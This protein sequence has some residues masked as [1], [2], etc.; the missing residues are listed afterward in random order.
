[1][2]TL[3]MMPLVAMRTPK[4]PDK[5]TLRRSVDLVPKLPLQSHKVT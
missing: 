5:N 1:M 2:K 4:E 3:Y